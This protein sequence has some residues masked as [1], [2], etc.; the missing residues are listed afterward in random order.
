MKKLIFLIAGILSGAAIFAQQ[1]PISENYFLDK[2]SLSPSYAGNYNPK[3][4][5]L[6][7]RS[8][9]SGIDGGPKTLRLS[10]NDAYKQNTGYGAKFIYDKVGIFKQTVFMITY[11]YKVTVAKEHFLLFGLS[12][13][14]YSNTINFTD[15]YNDPKYNLDP[16]LINADVSSKLKF[17]S[18]FSGLYKFKGFETGLLFSNINFGDSKY[19]APNVKYKPLANYQY[20]ASYLFN[21][22]D[23][24]DVEPM[25]ILRG[26]RYIKSQFEFASQVVYQKA[27][28][29]SLV[30]R[31]PG[32]WGIGLGANINRGLKIQYNFNIASAVAPRYYNNHEITLGINIFKF[33]TPK[34]VNPATNKPYSEPQ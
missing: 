21:V 14:F 24:W 26:G 33:T 34:G 15:F 19:Q 30:F 27:V 9:W 25:L 23:K 22:S 28:W 1:M 12:A 17:M 3:F 2:Y 10:Y 5:F 18:D 8:D 32:I 6:G 13:G 11:S 16:A 4:L 20:H 31:D 29:G 7:Y